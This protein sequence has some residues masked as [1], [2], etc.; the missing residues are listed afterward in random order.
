MNKK[1]STIIISFILLFSY[2]TLFEFSSAQTTSIRIVVT[3]DWHHGASTHISN[4]IATIKAKHP[5]YIFDLGDVVED[6]YNS[7]HWDQYASTVN[8][9]KSAGISYFAIPGDHDVPDEHFEWHEDRFMD[10]TNQTSASFLIKIGNNVFIFLRSYRYNN[11]WESDYMNESSTNI[12]QGIWTD[13]QLGWLKKILQK[14]SA[15]NNIFL[16][17]HYAPINSTAGSWGWWGEGKCEYRTTADRWATI[18]M[19]QTAKLYSILKN[20]TVDVLMHGHIHIDP[21]TF[22]DGSWDGN[23]KVLGGT[24]VFG[25]ATS[26]LPQNTTFVLVGNGY[27]EHSP[28]PSYGYNSNYATFR[29]FDLVTG[30]NYFTLYAWNA[31]LNGSIGMTVNASS[32]PVTSINIPLR[33]PIELDEK[34]IINYEEFAEP[35]EFSDTST[36]QY[37]HDA[38]GYRFAAD[39]WFT[40]RFDLWEENEITGINIS[41]FENPAGSGSTITYQI[42]KSTDGMQT[43]QE[44]TSLP[45][46]ARWIMLNV[47]VNVNS[48]VYIQ[49]ISLNTENITN[50]PRILSCYGHSPV[51]NI[52]VPFG[53]PLNL[54]FDWGYIPNPYQYKIWIRSLDGSFN[55]TTTINHSDYLAGDHIEYIWGSNNEPQLPPNNYI[56]RV[57]CIYKVGVMT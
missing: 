12:R 22:K 6:G 29:Y 16:M 42:Y 57:K 53:T 21:T 45:V 51:S 10:A 38:Y 56:I 13:Q 47:T 11:V 8:T 30:Q 14:Y 52:S 2:F 32:T 43:W 9:L 24:V 27:P 17:T 19:H 23:T 7:A 25:S 20:Y 48:I 34:N 41:W 18:T 39:R 28:P 36:Q 4:L 15:S 40:V 26:H 46:T 50:K 35:Y 33:F 5:D 54:S 1:I 44:V 31:D 49:N 37:I 55:Y 3:S